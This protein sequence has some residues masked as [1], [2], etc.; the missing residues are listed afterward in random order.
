MIGRMDAAAPVLATPRLELRVPALGDA[1]F[2]LALLND[3]SWLE[4]IGDRGVRSAADAGRYIRETL[5]APYAA[6]GFGLCVVQLKATGQPI[7]VCGLLKRDFLPGPD[8]GFALLPEFVGFGY[9]SEAARAVLAHARSTL[10]LARVYA[11]VKRGNRRSGKLLGALGF[12]PL[13]SC[14]IPEGTEVELYVTT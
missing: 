1:P 5:Q 7:G 10:G 9:A 6:L 3:P 2:F 4:N 13:G 14:L 11:I 12:Q 8:L